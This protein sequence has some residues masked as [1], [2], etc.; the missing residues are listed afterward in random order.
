[1]RAVFLVVLLAVAP[2]A[3]GDE[4]SF[5][6][7]LVQGGLVVGRVEAG[8]RVTVDG[9][10]VRVS[11]E[12]LFLIGFGRDAPPQLEVR[13]TLSGGA[14]LVRRLA[15]EGRQYD[16]QRIDGLP[17]RQV[18]PGAAELERIG[19]DNAAI[20]AVRRRDLGQAFFAS[21]FAWPVR[22]RLSGLFG[23][24]RILNGQPRSPH[25]GVDV[26]A[27][28]GA[29]VRAAADGVVALAHADMFYTGKTLMID[30]GHGLTTVYAHMS[31]ILVDQG[32]RVAR[33]EAV[34]RVGATG[35][36]TGPHLHWGVSLF[37][38]HLDPALLAGPH[39]NAHSY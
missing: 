34:G 13:V 15:V 26:A 39:T 32:Q 38:T 16:E 36:A 37:G 3:A 7:D 23:T 17:G 22:G 35:R 5:S 9:R 29:Q 4:V 24:R 2:A 28:R 21:G 19:A 6:G 12:G 25:N 27:D 18:T 14:L 8:A 31:E 20:A 10:Q 11:P 30:H 1:M 33:G